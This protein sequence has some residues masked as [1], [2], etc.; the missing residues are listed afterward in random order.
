VS[1]SDW[2]FYSS[3]SGI[4]VAIRSTNALVGNGMLAMARNG[5]GTANIAS[6]GILRSGNLRGFGK[7]FLRSLVRIDKHAGEANHA[8]GLVFMMSQTNL[9][10]S[11]SCYGAMLRT[12]D[13][14]GTIESYR[15]VKYTAGIVAPTSNILTQ[16]SGLSLVKGTM[17]A[18]EVE[19]ALD[20][21]VPSI[22]II[23]RRGALANFSDLAEVWTVTLT[24][25][26]L[27]NTVGEGPAVFM[28]GTGDHESVFDETFS[29]EKS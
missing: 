6:H 18:I 23:G 22:Q 24:T 2:D 3:A 13:V 25:D 10:S 11:G 29:F 26:V 7:G 14:S 9:S 5:V 28:A 17:V 4:L 8:M 27:Q 1:F 20:T 15:L 21:S 12:S 19:W 16:E